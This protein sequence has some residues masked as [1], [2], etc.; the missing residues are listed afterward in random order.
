MKPRKFWV[1]VSHQ[2]SFYFFIFL[3]FSTFSIFTDIRINFHF[4]FL[5][6]LFFSTFSI[7][8]DIRIVMFFFFIFFKLQTKKKVER[9]HRHI[10]VPLKK[11]PWQNSRQQGSK[12]R[13]KNFCFAKKK[14]HPFR[15]YT[16]G[17]PQQERERERE[18]ETRHGHIIIYSLSTNNH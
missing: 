16:E 18:R 5:F 11:N 17:G 1:F 12:K 3:F 7:F 9:T 13:K 15:A 6:F 10:K 4:T 2:L 14:I 8:T